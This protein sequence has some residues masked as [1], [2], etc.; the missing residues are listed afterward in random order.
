MIIT[1]NRFAKFIFIKAK[2]HLLCIPFYSLFRTLAN[3]TSMSRWIANQDKKHLQHPSV[4]KDPSRYGLYGQV[5]H[6]E[7]LDGP[8][9]YLEFG[10]AQGLSFTWWVDT[11]KDPGSTFYGFDTF[12]GLPEDWGVFKKGH[13]SSGLKPPEITDHRTQFLTGLF[14]KTLSD[15]LI[16]V[17]LKGKRKVIH[18]DADLYSS[19]L[20]VLTRLA[21]YLEKGDIIIFDEFTVPNHEFLAFQEFIQSYYLHFECIGQRQNFFNVAFKLETT[22]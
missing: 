4:T 22:Q 7:K 14:Q 18:M 3:M 19:T 10:V 5:L 21:P 6:E 1:V 15:F 8:I 17:P 16:S 9:Q 2:L 12:D 20:F 11:N 13:F